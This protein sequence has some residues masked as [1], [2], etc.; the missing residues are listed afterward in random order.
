[1]D[2]KK[3]PSTILKIARD[4]SR[5]LRKHYPLEKIVVFGSYAKGTAQ[6]WSDIDFAVVS[7]SLGEDTHDERVALSKISRNID[8]RIES[9]PFT[10]Q[11]FED[12]WNPL[13]VEIQ[14]TGI[15]VV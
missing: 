13:A 15:I 9:H 10:P 6:P 3:L 4:Y 11:E 8:A 7:Q 1:M 5:V 14:K 2:Q 12:P